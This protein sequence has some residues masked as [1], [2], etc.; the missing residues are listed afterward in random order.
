MG[1]CI[2]CGKE[3]KL[4]IRIDIDCSPIYTHKKCED[5]VRLA[6]VMLG[7]SIRRGESKEH[8]IQFTK[9]WYEPI[10]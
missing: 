5:D 10:K 9:D 1:K 7:M 2:K 3:T 6:L 8:A 4:A